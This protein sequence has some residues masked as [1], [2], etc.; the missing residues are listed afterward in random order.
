MNLI[1]KSAAYV[2][3]K[4]YGIAGAAIVVMM[5][6]SC[7]DVSL[8]YFRMGVPG[9]F[10][11]VCLLGSVA[12]AFAMAHTMVEGGH[13]AVSL[14]VRYFPE[15]VQGV[16][17]SV[18][19]SF[20]IIFFLIVTWQSVVYGN[21][22]RVASEVSLALKVPLY[23]FVYGIAFGAAAITFVLLGSLSGSLREVFGQ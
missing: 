7:I 6:L 9:T 17:A 11:L 14:I 19:D 10:E 18:T 3:R 22:L 12:A 1:E 21:E 15:R 4:L 20:G 8:R 16:I 13:V 2:A 5:M 23:P